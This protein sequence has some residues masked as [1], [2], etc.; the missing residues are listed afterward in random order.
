M[1]G[2]RSLRQLIAVLGDEPVPEEPD[3]DRGRPDT[4]LAGLMV[5]GAGLGTGLAP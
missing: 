5:P 2:V 1:L 3:P 4:M